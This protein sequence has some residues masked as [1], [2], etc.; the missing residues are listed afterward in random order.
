MCTQ[1]FLRLWV[2]SRKWPTRGGTADE[3]EKRPSFW[4]PRAVFA[5]YLRALAEEQRAE[6]LALR[7]KPGTLHVS[8][9]GPFAETGNV[10]F[11][12]RPRLAAVALAHR[13]GSP[14]T[15]GPLQLPSRTASRR[16]RHHFGASA[17]QRSLST[18]KDNEIRIKRTDVQEECKG[19]TF[20]MNTHHACTLPGPHVYPAR[21]S[22]VPCQVLTCTLPGPTDTWHRVHSA[23]S[24]TTFPM[25]NLPSYSNGKT[26]VVRCLAAFRFSSAGLPSLS[27]VAVC[28]LALYRKHPYSRTCP[29]RSCPTRPRVSSSRSGPL[30]LRKRGPLPISGPN[31]SPQAVP[32]VGQH[33]KQPEPPAVPAEDQHPAS[34]GA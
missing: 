6:E 12:L 1:G 11:T 22:C 33:P 7:Q 28:S 21:F 24:Y 3:R 9:C 2:E 30:P 16:I 8:P 10:G 15:R 4:P 20:D 23:H 32:A 17:L 26:V 34:V 27:A 5:R 31:V 19:P 25:V 13:P 14:S 29:P 18:T